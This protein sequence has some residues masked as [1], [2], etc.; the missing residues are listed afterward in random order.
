MHPPRRS[1]ARARPRASRAGCTR[2]QCGVTVAPSTLAAPTSADASAGPSSETSSW[3]EW[4]A[5][6]RAR[7]SC[8]GVRASATVPP[9]TQSH[10]ISSS[11]TTAPTSSIVAR[12]AARIDAA[13]AGPCRRASAAA[14]AGNSA[15][16]HPPLR[17]LAP[18]P[19][20][21]RSTTVTRRPGSA[22]S[23]EYAVQRPVYP[24]PTMQT[25]T[26]L[27]PANGGRGVSGSPDAASC[28][29]QSESE[30]RGGT[31]L[32]SAPPAGSARS[33]RTPPAR[34]RAAGR[35]G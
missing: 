10:A 16:H 18:K 6:A 33:R 11:A 20:T 21:S 3:P 31:T 25:S 12:I 32:R 5:S 26:S 1:T 8:A 7:T 27:S 23:S 28:S 29:C 17:P 13:A 34:R 19:A 4:A 2:A 35:A 30:L 14:P 24:A 15:E 22:R 9:F